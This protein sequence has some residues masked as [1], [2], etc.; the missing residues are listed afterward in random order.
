MKNAA[1]VTKDGG[2]GDGNKKGHLRPVFS[3]QGEKKAQYQKQ[4]DSARKRSISGLP[5][6]HL[7]TS[8]RLGN[9]KLLSTDAVALYHVLCPPCAEL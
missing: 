9:T 7:P 6:Y 5:Y 4:R 3:D 1:R 2:G 8:T